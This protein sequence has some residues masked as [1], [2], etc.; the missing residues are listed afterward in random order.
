MSRESVKSPGREAGPAPEDLHRRRLRRPARQSS[1]SSCRR[2]WAA[3]AARARHPRSPPLP[4]GAGARRRSSPAGKLPNTDRVVGRARLEPADLVRPL[5]EQGSVRPAAVDD[6]RGRRAARHGRP[7]PAEPPAAR[8][9]SRRRS[10]LPRRRPRVAD[11]RRRPSGVPSSPP[12]HASPRRAARDRPA[13][14]RQRRTPAAPAAAPTEALIATNGVC[15]RVSVDGHLPEQREHLPARLDRQE[16]QVGRGRHRRRLVRQRPA[17]GDAEGGREAHARQHGRRHALRDRAQG[18]LQPGDAVRGA[19][20]AT[21]STTATPVAPPRPTPATPADYR[22]DHDHG[23]DADRHRLARHDALPPGRRAMTSY[24]YTAI[25]ADGLELRGEVQATTAA[26]A[27]EQLRVQG[28]L[29]ELARGGGRPGGRSVAPRAAPRPSARAPRRR[30][31][32]V[33]ARSLQ[34]F[35]RQFATMI[36]AGLNVVTALTILEE[37]TDDTYLA[38]VIG[39]VRT[40]VEG[41]ALLSEALAEHPKVFSRIYVSMVEAGEAAG[42]LDN[43]LD[44]LATQIEKEANLKRR[45]KGAMVYPTMVISFAFL[46]LMRDAPLHRPDLPEALRAVQRQLPEADAV[47]DHRVGAAAAPAGSSSSRRSASPSSCSSAGRRARAA[48]SSGTASG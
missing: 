44:R 14:R 48:G 16:R 7:P 40:D 22:P 17:D 4:P 6:P 41:G 27:R 43:V 26:A 25:N 20:T 9:S 31:K 2:C 34:V 10:R 11:S 42:I 12:T 39:E 47:H 28:L 15:E 37:Q 33:K 18:E 8:A 3:R 45:V 19:T 46:V 38:A 30:R 21:Q 29:A 1:A 23:D 24:A 13:R 5:Q 36:D 35:S 32:R